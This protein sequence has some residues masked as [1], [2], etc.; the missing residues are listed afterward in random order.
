MQENAQIS[1]R[2]W[3]IMQVL[4]SRAPLSAEE[5]IDQ[6]SRK[7]NRHPKTVKTLLNRLI[8]KKALTFQKEGRS[9]LYRPAVTERECVAAES[10]SFL[11]RVFG[12][13]LTPMLAHFVR[14]RKLSE[15]ELQELEQ[16][17]RG[18]K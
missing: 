4:W 5:I 15:K 9:Y 2:E 11:Q 18:K 3:E 1:E 16:I 12:G 6:L 17:L 8:K 10:Q 14:Q 13:A 7:S